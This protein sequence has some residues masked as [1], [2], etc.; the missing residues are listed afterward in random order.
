MK[1]Y[2]TGEMILM[3]VW[4]GERVQVPGKMFKISF[5]QECPFIVQIICMFKTMCWTE[6]MTQEFLLSQV[7]CLALIKNL[8]KHWCHAFLLPRPVLLIILTQVMEREI[9]RHSSLASRVFQVCQPDSEMFPFNYSL[10]RALDC[11]IHWY[12]LI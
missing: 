10:K 11:V 1:L 2:R 3:N 4:E 5:T 8:T 12:N 7:I 9:T 6:I